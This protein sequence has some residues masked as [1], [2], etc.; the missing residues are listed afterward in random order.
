MGVTDARLFGARIPPLGDNSYDLILAAA[1]LSRLIS[2]ARFES[3]RASIGMLSAS[4]RGL[5]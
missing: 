1:I 4:G 5:I 3:S 2:F